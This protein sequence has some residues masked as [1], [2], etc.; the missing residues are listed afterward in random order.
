MGKKTK[1]T[2]FSDNSREAYEFKVHPAGTLDLEGTDPLVEED[3]S[4]AEK[5][6]EKLQEQIFELQVRYFLE[7]R[8]AIF[9]FEGW[10]AAGKG[11]AIK[12]LTAPMDPRGYKVWPIAAPKDAEARQHYLWRFF[13]RLPEMGEIAIFDRS[14]Y[15]RV[16]V[17]RVER[18]CSE[19]AW[20]RAYDEINAFERML[21]DDGVVLLKFFLHID[22]DTQMRRFKDREKDPIR[23]F[24]IGPDDW[25]NRKKWPDYLVAYQDMFDRTHRPDAPWVIVPAADK[26]HARLTVLKT[27]VQALKERL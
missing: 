2:K 7:K 18:F 15:G 11:G 22:A 10:D 1:K 8:R 23:Q 27:C 20:Q 26:R 5:A 17:E 25:R 16:L 21:T 12:R 19:K 13:T 14:W 6:I 4:K 9:V 24:K 3:K